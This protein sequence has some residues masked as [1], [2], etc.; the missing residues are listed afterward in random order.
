LTGLT[1]VGAITES[2][3]ARL[4]ACR[5]ALLSTRWRWTVSVAANRIRPRR[6]PLWARACA[7]AIEGGGVGHEAAQ[8]AVEELGGYWRGGDDEHGHEQADAALFHG[9]AG[10]TKEGE[11]LAPDLSAAI[12]VSRG[13]LLTASMAARAKALPV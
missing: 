13:V 9:L 1:K 2:G 5:V 10:S 7:R 11:V 6:L 4:T 3:V 8:G 12:S